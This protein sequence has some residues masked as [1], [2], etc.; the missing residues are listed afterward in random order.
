MDPRRRTT[1]LVSPETCS[2]VSRRE[3][4]F[5]EA[6]LSAQSNSSKACPRLSRP[7]ED[8]RRTRD[9]EAAACQGSKATRRH[10]AL[11]VVMPGSTGR[12]GREHRLRRSWEFQRVSRMGR[13]VASRSFVLIVSPPVR[14]E[15]SGRR[16]GVT[17]SRKVGNAVVRNRVKRRIRAWYREYRSQLAGDGEL[18]VIARRSASTLNGEATD[19]ALSTLLSAVERDRK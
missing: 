8:S 9:P 14:L 4:V 11:E 3:G 17:V 6:D 7:H 12:F 5:R 15:S 18:L 1:R 2:R 16:L 19:A 10:D 13:R